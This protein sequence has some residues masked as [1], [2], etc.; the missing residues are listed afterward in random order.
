MVT[1]GTATMVQASG[2]KNEPRILVHMKRT[3]GW[4]LWKKEN[5]I[6]VSKVKCIQIGFINA[7]MG[8]DALHLVG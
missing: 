8:L 6:N 3:S 4:M 2:R 1:M 7:F 5:L